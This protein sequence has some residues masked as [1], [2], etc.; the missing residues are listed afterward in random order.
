MIRKTIAVAVA[1]ALVPPLA[2]A[3]DLPLGD[4]HVSS[5]PRAGYVFSCQQR[6]N[7][8]APGAQAHG[9]WL[10][11]A[12]GTWD[13]SKKPV[14]DGDVKWPGKVAISLEGSSRII[15]ANGLPTTRTGTFPVSRSDDAYRYDRNPNTIRSSNVLLTLPAIPE[16]AAAA[17]CVPMGM[18]GFTV[19]GTAI[20]NAL[21]AR[22]D[23]AP[24][25][26]IQDRCNGHPEHDGTYHFHNYSGCFSDTKSGPNG[27][28]DLIGY[29][30]DGF[31]IFGMYENGRK[32]ANADL[33]ECHGRTSTVM[34]DGEL[35]EIYHYVFTDEYPYTIGCFRGAVSR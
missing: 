28:S 20:F 34:W 29:A 17:S 21:D 2:S 13:P 15:R 27:A 22:G 26:E 3:H 18:I 24:A 23:D 4:G 35:H 5:S 25:H 32:L 30:L 9:G 19:S 8:N 7:P 16:I 33:D 11:E 12:K 6:F 31:G 14:V 10:N 1:A